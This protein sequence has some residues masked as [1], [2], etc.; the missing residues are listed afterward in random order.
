CQD[1]ARPV[2]KEI[3]VGLTRR[4]DHDVARAAVVLPVVV[5]TREPALQ[6]DGDRGV[7][8]LVLLQVQSS[9][10][11]HGRDAPKWKVDRLDRCGAGSHR[12]LVSPHATNSATG[13]T[14]FKTPGSI[15]D[16]DSWHF[17]ASTRRILEPSRS[18]N[19][20]VFSGSSFSSRS[21]RSW[22]PRRLS[23]RALASRSLPRVAAGSSMPAPSR[24]SSGS[25]RSREATAPRA[26]RSITST[27]PT[28]SPTT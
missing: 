19:R 27:W 25:P 16:L 22:L 26:D 15:Q 14:A 9:R 4:L 23:Q 17:H 10:K 28:D 11:A 7:R 13:P 18:A 5:R 20:C 12:Y 21:S 6:D 2:P 8:M 24:C 3:R 1:C